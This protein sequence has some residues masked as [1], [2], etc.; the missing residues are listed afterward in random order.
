MS[1]QQKKT[2]NGILHGSTLSSR[3][4]IRFLIAI[5]IGAALLSFSAIILIQTVIAVI[6]AIPF[7]VISSPIT[8]PAGALLV[9]ITVGFLFSGCCCLGA[10]FALLLVYRYVAGKYPF[11]ADQIEYAKMKIASA[12]KDMK[13]MAKGYGHAA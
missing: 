12:A 4:V 2:T 7:L 3:K 5:A 8:I 11:I 1:D 6:L 9:L 10:V 13:H